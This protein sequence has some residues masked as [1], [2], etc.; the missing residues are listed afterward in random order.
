MG[1]YFK[2]FDLENHDFEIEYSFSKFTTP[3]PHLA[4]YN[5]LVMLPDWDSWG[6][7]TRSGILIIESYVTEFIARS[8][9]NKA[10]PDPSIFTD[11]TSLYD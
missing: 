5:D 10:T 1:L 8:Y 2:K 7:W 11:T 9:K 6:A 4:P 3:E